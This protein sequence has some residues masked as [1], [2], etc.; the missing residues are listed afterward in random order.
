MDNTS[1][2]KPDYDTSKIKMDE[3]NKK[4]WDVLVAENETKFIEYVF[5]GE[6]GKKLTYSQMR[7]LY[8]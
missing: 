6:N 8:G 3:T 7:N 4:A 5:N 2:I 1:K